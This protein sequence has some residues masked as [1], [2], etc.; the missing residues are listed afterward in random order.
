MT[1]KSRPLEY[2]PTWVVA[3]ICSIIVFIS[4]CAERGLHRLGKVLIQLDLYSVMIFSNELMLLGFISLLLTVV[5]DYISHLCIPTHIAS[6][7]LPC[8]LEDISSRETVLKNSRRFTSEISGLEHCPHEGKLPVLSLD[9]VHQLHIFIFVLA[10]VHVVF[11]ATTVVLGG[12]KMRQWKQWDDSIMTKVARSQDAPDLLNDHDHHHRSHLQ[13]FFMIRAITG[14]Y[15]KLPGVRWVLLLLVGAKL[16]HIITRLAREVVQKRNAG[17]TGETM[18][19]KPSS[20][21]FCF[22]RPVLV[23]YLIQFILFQN[24]FEIA[25]F[26]WI[27]G[28]HG[29]KSCVMEKVGY[30]IPR[31][32][33]GVIVQVLCS[34]ITLP[35]YAL[36]TQM[37][38]MFKQGIFNE[39]IHTLVEKW[40]E[41]SR[42]RTA[43]RGVSPS[44]KEPTSQTQKM[45]N[46]P[47]GCNDIDEE[48]APVDH[49]TETSVI[50]FSCPNQIQMPP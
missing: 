34:Y 4:F 17:T 18:P 28:T 12:A 39:Y 10:L 33:V 48:I 2:T 31:L 45:E 14:H 5:Q 20:E 30:I 15:R 21:H 8:K 40:A 47:F 42:E 24:S 44:P 9:A 16:E 37:G 41:D 32:V 22:N 49:A 19:V 27:W 46:Q 29:F 35:L 13:Q 43:K 36:V 3:A 6:Y 7:M 26:I 11:A 38:D 1:E 23:L 50:E 25:F